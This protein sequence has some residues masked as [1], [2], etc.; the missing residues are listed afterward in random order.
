MH[1]RLTG[2]SAT[3]QLSVAE[4]HAFALALAQSDDWFPLCFASAAGVGD[5]VVSKWRGFNWAAQVGSMCLLLH[6]LWMARLPQKKPARYGLGD[7]LL[8]MHK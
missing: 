3:R 6:S 1:A 4:S 8:C 5:L 7:P 2:Q